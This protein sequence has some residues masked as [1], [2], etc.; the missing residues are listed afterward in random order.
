L[1]Q[2]PEELIKSEYLRAKRKKM[3]EEFKNVM[4]TSSN[5][6][7]ELSKEAEIKKNPNKILD[8]QKLL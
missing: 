2:K 5:R 3:T 7:D 1:L 6:R 4:F 8:N